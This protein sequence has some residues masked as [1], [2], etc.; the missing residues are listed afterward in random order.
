MS[1]ELVT[2]VW[3]AETNQLHRIEPER[4]KI[5]SYLHQQILTGAFVTALAIKKMFDEK[6]YLELGCSSRDEYIET[7]SPLNRRQAYKYFAVANRFA[8][9]IPLSEKVHSSALESE[10]TGETVNEDSPKP[11]E[12]D[13][14]RNSSSAFS[15]IGIAKLYELLSLPEENLEE[16]ITTGKTTVRDLDKLT[17][18]EITEKKSRE[19]AKQMKEMR[20]QLT[21]KLS[22]LEQENKKLKSEAEAAADR[23]AEAEEMWRKGMELESKYI[24]PERSLEGKRQSLARANELLSELMRAVTKIEITPEDPETEQRRCLDFLRMLAWFNSNARDH[25]GPILLNPNL[26]D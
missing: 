6:L 22:R 9:Y 10:N 4:Q 16:L 2:T 21:G 24:G 25:F 13:E 5:A 14:K 19:F 12:N 11:G 20:Q 7:M 8:K 18:E 1:N 17:I 15:K 23:I 26:E 3:D